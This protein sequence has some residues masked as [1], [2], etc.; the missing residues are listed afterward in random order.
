MSKRDHLSLNEAQFF[1]RAFEQLKN[2]ENESNFEFFET[3]QQ[4]LTGNEILVAKN[5]ECS[6]FMEVYI[7][8]CPAEFLH[9]IFLSLGRSW[10]DLCFDPSG[11][12]VA[13]A[14]INESAEYIDSKEY[15][16]TFFELFVNFIT[17]IKG[18]VSDLAHDKYGS[19]VLRRII[20]QISE[21]GQLEKHIDKLSRQLIQGYKSDKGQAREIHYSAVL[22]TLLD[23]DQSNQVYKKITNYLASTIPY[24]EDD[25]KDQFASHLYE[26][27][28]STCPD[29]AINTLYNNVLKDRAV[30]L[31]KHKFGNHVLKQWILNC[32]D[33]DKVKDVL[34]QLLA[35]FN[36]ILDESPLVMHAFFN[37]ASRVPAIQDQLVK[38]LKQRS[39]DRNIIE[40]FL[41]SNNRNAG[42][43]ILQEILRY[44]DKFSEYAVGAVLSLPDERLKTLCI[45]KDGTFVISEFF[46]SRIKKRPKHK[47]LK[48]IIPFAEELCIDRRGSYIIEDAFRAADI[49]HKALLCE[50][51][52]N[53]DLKNKCPKIYS[54]FKLQNF[55]NRRGQWEYEMRVLTKRE[56]EMR[57]MESFDQITPED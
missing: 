26:K 4:Q 6:K 50:T 49:E 52:I 31:S 13:E 41:N 32:N 7:S 34:D 51:L 43:R 28:I 19:H 36:E 44:Q 11:S 24:T 48:K 53:L 46:R 5:K 42:M 29:I 16:P 10:G 25:V 56:D 39:G 35:N 20:K 47:L 2:K 54:N 40:E 38:F 1:G 21:K 30:N 33:G 22:Q 55:T 18:Y 23:L 9:Q 45:D 27:V 57:G 15:K 37:A 3:L 8:K 14:L 12:R 17:E